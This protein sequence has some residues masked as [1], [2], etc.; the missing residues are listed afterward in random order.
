VG[1]EPQPAKRT[2]LKTPCSPFPQVIAT[3][4]R[5]CFETVTVT[6]SGPERMTSP[7]FRQ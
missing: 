3:R 2:V 1:F 6:R 7:A 5:Q 4:L